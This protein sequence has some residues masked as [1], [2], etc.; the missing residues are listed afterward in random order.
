MR[1]RQLV[2]TLIV[3]LVAICALG[4]PLAYF[5]V[6]S[7][8][9]DARNG[10]LREADTVSALVED[11][12]QARLPLTNVDLAHFTPAKRRVIVRLGDGR[13]VTA[14]EDVGRHPYQVSQQIGTDG[15][16]Q[17]ERTAAGVHQRQLRAVGIVVGLAALAALIAVVLA[18]RSARRLSGPLQRLA[19]HADRLGAG[20][21]RPSDVRY[22]IGELDAVAVVLD[23]TTLRVANLVERERRLVGDISHQLRSGLTA[24]SMRL[25]EITLTSGDD[26]ARAEA[27]IALGQSDRLARVIDELLAQAR[28]DRAGAAVTLDIAEQLVELRREFESPL[29]A[30]GRELRIEAP[31][32]LSAWA[33]PGRLH[34]SLGVLLDNAHQ[35]GEGTVRVTARV[36]GRHVLVE[37]CDEGSGVPAEL[38]GRIFD[39]GISGGSGTGLGLGLARSLLDADGGRLELR[40]LSPATF[41][42]FL[43][44]AGV[45][46]DR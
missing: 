38:A 20:D 37:V 42:V 34:Q 12:V 27:E 46:D 39:R 16:V 6:H 13:S 5:V 31:S 1:R 32:G 9:N 3:V 11:R 26:H 33:T 25:E 43:P 35:H 14:G 24:L 19:E 10:L 30:E 29:H 45:A 41:G 17:I 36:A 21:F 44:R 18:V 8:S 7:A 23:S 22:G 15:S 40:S 2:S 28:Q 4:I